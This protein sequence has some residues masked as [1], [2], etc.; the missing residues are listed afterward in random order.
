MRIGM[1]IIYR[2]THWKLYYI[3]LILLTETIIKPFTFKKLILKTTIITKAVNLMHLYVF[4][5]TPYNKM[6][7]VKIC[8]DL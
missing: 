4:F 6:D 7:L 5:A 2:F 8:F 1:I 3:I